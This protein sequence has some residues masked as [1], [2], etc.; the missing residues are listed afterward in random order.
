MKQPDYLVCDSSDEQF[1][2]IFSMKRLW[3]KAKYLFIRLFNVR[4]EE[5][6]LKISSAHVLTAELKEL[7]QK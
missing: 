6:K 7:I 4:K 5:W 2:S 3:L 1:K